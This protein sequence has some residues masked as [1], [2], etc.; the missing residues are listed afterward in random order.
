M[1]YMDRSL[2]PTLG[3]LV[4]FLP[5]ILP[6]GEDAVFLDHVSS[7]PDCFQGSFFGSLR[8]G[9]LA[10]PCTVRTGYCK[11]FTAVG[12]FFKGIDL[13]GNTLDGR[14]LG[15]CEQKLV[16]RHA[17][18]IHFGHGVTVGS[19]IEV[20][21][22]ITAVEAPEIVLGGLHSKLRFRSIFDT[23]LIQLR[24]TDPPVFQGNL[25]IFTP[26]IRIADHHEMAFNAGEGVNILLIFEERFDGLVSSDAFRDRSIFNGRNP[27]GNGRVRIFGYD[28]NGK[29]DLFMDLQF[30]SHPG[31]IGVAVIGAGIA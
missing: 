15:E 14:L 6:V 16:S 17:L 12:V 27:N 19:S 11:H 31:F 1:R 9:V 20:R 3:L 13:P 2:F 4:E 24:H 10:Q 22:Q 8:R 21:E 30:A 26:S 25:D 5:R 7:C 18:R 29:S 23:I 28:A